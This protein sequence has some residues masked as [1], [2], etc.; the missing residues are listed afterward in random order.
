ML[1]EKFTENL[2]YLQFFSFEVLDYFDSICTDENYEWI[3]KYFDV[4]MKEENKTAEKFD[5]HHIVPCAL[6]KDENHKIRNET[7]V[8]ANEIDGNL[9]KLSVQ[10][11]IIAHHC[12]WKMFPTNEDIRRPIYLMLGKIDIDNLTE[13][14]LQELARIQE[15][16]R[17]SNMTE[18]E[19]K[20]YFSQWHLK[21]KEERNKKAKE[22]YEN[23]REEEAEKARKR[24]ENNKEEINKKERERY[25]NN[26]EKYRKRHKEYYENNKE[27]I[28][29]QRKEHRKNHK[30]ELSEKEKERRERLCYDPIEEENC[31]YNTL[32]YRKSKNKEKYKDVILKDCIIQPKPQS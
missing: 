22:R 27:E 26:K 6:L 18:E 30:E 12:L 25:K 5:K 31:N 3:V 10:N 19:K 16:C 23:N 20:E 2:N 14:E 1:R 15:D 11:H 24:R 17:K 28:S 32:K 13:N 4:L 8:L 29:K 7:V 9:V 21:H